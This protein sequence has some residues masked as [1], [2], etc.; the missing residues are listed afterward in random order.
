VL[1]VEDEETVRQ[2]VSDIVMPVMDG[3]HLTAQ[4]RTRFPGVPTVWMSGYPREN[5][6]EGDALPAGAPFLQK[7]V[8]PE[9]LIET[10]RLAVARGEGRST[11]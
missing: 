2:I 4:L 11:S 10:V 3:R 9:L 5:L 6:A 1:L 8:P 7:P